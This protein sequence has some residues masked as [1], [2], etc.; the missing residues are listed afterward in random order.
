MLAFAARAAVVTLSVLAL[1]ALFGAPLASARTYRWL[2]LQ[3]LLVAAPAAAHLRAW[4]DVPLLLC[5]PEAWP[6]AAPLLVPAAGALFGSWAGAVV[7]PLDWGTAWQAWPIGSTY[8]SVVGFAL[9]SLILGVAR[10]AAAVCPRRVS[11]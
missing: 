3:A 10:C 6:R 11:P 1:A 8:G 5:Q 4:V 2:A 7:I 9:G